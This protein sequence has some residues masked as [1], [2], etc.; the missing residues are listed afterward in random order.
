RLAASAHEAA[1]AAV[2]IG[3][4]V[5]LKI[6]SPDIPHKTEA[7]GVRLGLADRRAVTEAYEAI[8]AACRQYRPEARIDGVLVECM[9][10]AGPELGVGM[11]NDATFGPIIMVGW[12]G[13]MVELMGDVVH[14]PAPVDRAEASRMIESLRSAPLLRG[15]RGG[16]A[17][18]AGPLAELVAQLSSVALGARDRIAEIELNPV[19]LHADG[20]GLTVAD[21]LITLTG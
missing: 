1:D 13:V 5:A 8:I 12:G 14:R 21:A 20:S 11:V 3:F 2:A 9:A 18:D 10:P 6:Q 7:G 17:V 15:F 16:P 4:P 19:I